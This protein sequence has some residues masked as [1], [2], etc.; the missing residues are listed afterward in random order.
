MFGRRVRRTAKESLGARTRTKPLG[1][2]TWFKNSRGKKRKLYGNK[3][4]RGSRDDRRKEEDT[5]SSPRSVLFF[6]QIPEGELASRLRE[7]LSRM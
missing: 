1:K 7:V 3:R 6:E 2:S 5:T 4:I